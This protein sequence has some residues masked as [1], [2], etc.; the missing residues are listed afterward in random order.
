[1]ITTLR[2]LDPNYKILLVEEICNIYPKQVIPTATYEHKA[3][4]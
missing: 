4:R 3:P 2:L 1:M